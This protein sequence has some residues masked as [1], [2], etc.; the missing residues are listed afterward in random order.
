VVRN[1]WRQ[2]PPIASVQYYEFN[3]TE[4]PPPPT[5]KTA[6]T[7]RTA[8]STVAGTSAV[9]AATLQDD[10]NAKLQDIEAARLA[11]EANFQSRMNDMD[12]TIAKVRTHLDEITATVTAQVLVGLQEENGLLW[13][14]DKK[15]EQLQEKLL[16]LLPF[17]KQAINLPPGTAASPRHPSP[18]SPLRK[19][20]RLEQDS[21]MDTVLHE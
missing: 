12:D 16:E 2:T 3:N 17:V 8:E 1:P 4:F 14:Q 5:H 15:I 20:R 6:T 9:T 19:N 7:A 10:F 21:T 18:L 13:T 11:T